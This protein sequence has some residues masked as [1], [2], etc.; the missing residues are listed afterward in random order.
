ME[1]LP[2]FKYPVTKA[3]LDT[4]GM[5]IP[6]SEFPGPALMQHPSFFLP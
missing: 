3:V 5:V 2:D 6:L 4:S 1:N